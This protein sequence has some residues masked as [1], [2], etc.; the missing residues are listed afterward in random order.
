MDESRKWDRPSPRPAAGGTGGARSVH[1]A[2]D[3]AVARIVGAVGGGPQQLGLAA[4]DH[5]DLVGGDAPVVE[6]VRDGGRPALGEGLV[7]SRRPGAVGVARDLD[8]R[9]PA[10]AG[11]RGRLVQ[12]LPH[13]GVEGVAA[14]LEEDDDVAIDELRRRRGGDGRRR[15][16]GADNGPKRDEREGGQA[17]DAT[18]ARGPLR[19][20]SRNAPPT[21]GSARTA[22]PWRLDGRTERRVPV[23]RRRPG[24][25]D[26]G[27]K[28]CRS[29]PAPPQV[30]RAMSRERDLSKPLILHHSI[31]ER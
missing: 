24:T 8:P 21:A 30:A 10:G 20:W 23:P 6:R 27:R 15:V 13:G 9:T 22:G 14:G 1:V 18:H 28:A 5:H 29:L 25:E 3:P 12:R 7:V 4:A 26:G 16:V 19:G 17:K 31:L 11:D 2:L